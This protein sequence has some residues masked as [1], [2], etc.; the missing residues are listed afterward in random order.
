TFSDRSSRTE[1]IPSRDSGRQRNSSLPVATLPH[2]SCASDCCPAL[3]VHTELQQPV[4]GRRRDTDQAF[5]PCHPQIYWPFK[6]L[7]HCSTMSPKPVQPASSLRGAADR[8][9]IRPSI[10]PVLLSAPC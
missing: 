8:L 3:Q 10:P 4:C 9:P 6:H 5:P 1:R 7:R 2:R